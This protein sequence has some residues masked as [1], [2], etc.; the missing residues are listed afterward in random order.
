MHMVYKGKVYNLCCP[1]CVKDFE[2][3]PEKY[4]GIINKELET[5]APAQDA[6]DDGE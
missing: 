5:A 1:M 2:N 4:I 6:G 3:D